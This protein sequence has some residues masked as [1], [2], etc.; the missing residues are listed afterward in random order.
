MCIS[1]NSKEKKHQQTRLVQVFLTIEILLYISFLYLD[2]TN[3]YL[4]TGYVLNISSV[5]SI[6]KAIKFFSILICFLFVALPLNDYKLKYDSTDLNLL[7]F[8]IMFTVIS[9]YILLFSDNVILGLLT[10]IVVQMCYLARVYRWKLKLRGTHKGI[11]PIYQYILRNILLLVVSL[12][13]IN[14]VLNLRGLNHSISLNLNVAA[15]ID[16]TDKFV[17]VLALYYFISLILNFIDSV[18]VSRR[19]NTTRTRLFS[20]GL[21][22]F[23]LC[24]I[25]VG[26]CNLPRLVTI[27][28]GIYETVHNFTK[29]GMWLFYLPSQVIISLSK[30]NN[31]L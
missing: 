10:F 18:K 3:T 17:I 12:I 9:D 30:T 16:S 22:L 2:I 8:A 20:L 14:I 15:S 31:K 19:A 21:L 26:L 23:I 24:D 5:F 25:N 7:R 27:N 4:N 1:M 13:L 28:K 6:S 11:R 29:I